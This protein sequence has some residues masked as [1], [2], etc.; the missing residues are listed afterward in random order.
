MRLLT[1]GEFRDSCFL[2]D[3]CSF[4]GDF[5]CKVLLKDPLDG[6]LTGE[7]HELLLSPNE[8]P[9]VRESVLEIVGDLDLDFDLLCVVFLGLHMRIFFAFLLLGF[10]R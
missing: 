10:I 4:D 7:F 2:A 8:I 6:V 9:V 3:R 5:L 1:S